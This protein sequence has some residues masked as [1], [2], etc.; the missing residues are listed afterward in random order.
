MNKVLEFKNKN[1]QTGK[2]EVVGTMEIK[3]QTEEKAELYFYGDICSSTRGCWEEEDKCPQDVS[4]FLKEIDNNKDLDI[5]INS[6]GGSVFGGLAIYHQLNRH[7]GFKTVHVDG[8]AASIMSVIALVGDKVIIPAP[9]QFMI[10]KPWTIA[11]GNANEFRKQAND[12]DIAEESI[13]KIYEAN[14]NEGVNIET[15]KQLMADETWMTGEKAAEYFNIEVEETQELVACTSQYF[16]EY[17]NMPKNLFAKSIKPKELKNKDHFIKDEEIE[18]LISRVN[19]TL[20]FEE[21]R[22]NE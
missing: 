20:K 4:N 9:A 22:I 8:L 17:K 6:G 10:H 1:K 16:N 2:E 5:Y 14:L 18:A 19:N 3:N 15:I 12:L 13:L 21:E 7:N 11:L